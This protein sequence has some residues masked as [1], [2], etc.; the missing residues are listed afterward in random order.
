M[1]I[2]KSS[3]STLDLTV[4]HKQFPDCCEIK[5]TDVILIAMYIPPN[6]SLY[7]KDEY[8]E[9]LKLLISH[10]AKNKT[11]YILGDLN[12]RVGCLNSSG[13]TYHRNPDSHINTN[14]RILKGILNQ[15]S[16]ITLLNGLMYKNRKFDTKFSFLEEIVPLRL[17]FVSRAMLIALTNYLSWTKCHIQTIALLSLIYT[18]HSGIHTNTVTPAQKDSPATNIMT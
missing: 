15:Y 10:Y 16:N 5:D 11:V 3:A 12:A 2:Y 9:I 1:A 14:G 7:Y 13:Q 18:R 8:F 4:L 17:T 6:N